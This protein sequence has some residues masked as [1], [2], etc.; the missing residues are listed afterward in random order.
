VIPFPTG[1]VIERREILHARPWLVIPMRV[2]ADDADLL[3]LHLTEGT[4][5]TFPE[6]P[7]GPHP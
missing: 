1:R 6:H 4:P 2:V 3:A 5:L 7:F